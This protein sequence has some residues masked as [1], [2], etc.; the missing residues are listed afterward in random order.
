V[1][2]DFTGNLNPPT[3]DA[4]RASERALQGADFLRRCLKQVA[5]VDLFGPNDRALVTF[6]TPAP[7]AS[8]IEALSQAGAMVRSEGT[9]ESTI[10]ASVGWWHRRSQLTGLANAIEA[11]LTSRILDPI[12]HDR[13]DKVPR[14]LPRRRLGTIAQPE[15][16]EFV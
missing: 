13:F 6:L 10:A 14:D 7:A 8:L 4:A 2:A 5:G 15:P 1:K 12:E 11:F 3:A 16:E 9:W